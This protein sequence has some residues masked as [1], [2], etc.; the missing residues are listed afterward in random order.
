M[1]RAILNVFSDFEQ[2]GLSLTNEIQ[3]MIAQ[4]I[5]FKIDEMFSIYG[6][7]I[8]QFME[9]ANK[10]LNPIFIIKNLNYCDDDLAEP[11]TPSVIF[12]SLQQNHQIQ[13]QYPQEYKIKSSSTLRQLFDTIKQPL[14]AQSIYFWNVIFT[15]AD[16]TLNFLNPETHAT[17][18][19]KIMELVQLKQK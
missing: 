5:E 12:Y 17:L 10:S 11:P 19:I 8:K 4:D 2:H 13:L 6:Q 15:M 3:K 7:K 14:G 1:I 9:Y 16:S 18:S